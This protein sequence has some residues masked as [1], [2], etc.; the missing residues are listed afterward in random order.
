MH[1]SVPFLSL[2]NKASITWCDSWSVILLKNI[3]P[4]MSF[5]RGQ[6]RLS[7]KNSRVG[8]F[9]GRWGEGHLTPL[10]PPSLRGWHA[11]LTAWLESNT[12]ARIVNPTLNSLVLKWA[13]LT[14]FFF[15][16]CTNLG[17]E[18]KSIYVRCHDF[19]YEILVVVICY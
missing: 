6:L 10:D 18:T 4:L 19:L 3:C 1:Y 2:A 17:V 15:L 14:L 7:K 9:F 13:T 12:A 11:K 5:W 16:F 8:K